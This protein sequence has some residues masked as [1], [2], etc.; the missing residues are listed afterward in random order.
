MAG[1]ELALGWRACYFGSKYDAKARKE[2][3][4]FPRSYLHSLICET[5]LAQKKH[6]NWIPE[7]TYKNFYAS[8]GHRLTKISLSLS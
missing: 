1:S 5:C 4:Q 7:L 6:K 8:A 3:N 2:I